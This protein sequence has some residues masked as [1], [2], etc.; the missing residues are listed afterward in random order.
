[1]HALPPALP[2]VGSL[3][4]VYSGLAGVQAPTVFG[5]PK[6]R[7]PVCYCIRADAPIPPPCPSLSF[8]PLPPSLTPYLPSRMPAVHLCVGAYSLLGVF[9]L[10]QLRIPGH[11]R[12][13]DHVRRGP[14]V[15]C[16]RVAIPR[17]SPSPTLGRRCPAWAHSRRF[18]W[19][20]PSFQCPC[21]RPAGGMPSR[22][23]A[24]YHRPLPRYRNVRRGLRPRV[25]GIK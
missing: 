10:S 23:S 7:S 15:G 18:V 6:K 1:M 11:Q 8:P 4:R 21:C 5:Q 3:V 9:G 16:W 12:A 14:I 24:F 17:A 13:R 20:V 2:L 25:F 19:R 22:W